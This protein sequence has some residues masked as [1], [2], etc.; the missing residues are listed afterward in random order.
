MAI[1]SVSDLPLT[2][3]QKKQI[4]I[5]NPCLDLPAYLSK[6][7]VSHLALATDSTSDDSEGENDE[8]NDD[9]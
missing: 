6:V 5:E 4:R 1:R 2:Q 7:L 8:E 9:D 3:A